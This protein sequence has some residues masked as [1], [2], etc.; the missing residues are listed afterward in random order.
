MAYSKK[1]IE[2]FEKPLK[3]PTIKLKKMTKLEK[4][5]TGSAKK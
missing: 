2:K 3:K 4:H 5:S 1:V